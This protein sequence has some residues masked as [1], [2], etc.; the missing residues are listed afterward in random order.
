MK[1]RFPGRP[2]PSFPWWPPRRGCPHRYQDTPSTVGPDQ[3]VV[4]LKVHPLVGQSIEVIRRVRAH[5]GRV[6][7]DLLH[8]DGRAVRLPVEWTDL[9]VPS[10]DPSVATRSTAGGLLALRTFLE[11]FRGEGVDMSNEPTNTSTSEPSSHHRAPPRTNHLAEADDDGAPRR[12][13][14]GVGAPGVDRQRG[15]EP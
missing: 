1:A 8:P 10:P 13:L 15:E 3:V 2:S 12:D 7:L 5:D 9:A 11:S 6:Y 14:G 4:T